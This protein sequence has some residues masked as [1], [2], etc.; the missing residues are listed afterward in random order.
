MEPHPII[1]FSPR[2]Q[3]SVV[4]VLCKDFNYEKSSQFK[5]DF[6]KLDLGG[7]K[8]PLIID[9]T[10]VSII[11]SMALG[12]LV[13]MR[14]RFGNEGRPFMLAGVQPMVAKILQ[15]SGVFEMFHLHHDLT[16]ALGAMGSAGSA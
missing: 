16:A 2:T 8:F 11:N 13:E 3:A 6:K 7:P 12:A 1:K 15:T 9:L 4:T 5:T 10:R 14:S